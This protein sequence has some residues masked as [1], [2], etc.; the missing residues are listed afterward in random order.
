[1]KGVRIITIDPIGVSIR[2]IAQIDV[3]PIPINPIPDWTRDTSASSV[4]AAPPVVLDIG[5]PIVNIPGC[6]EAHE[7][8]NSKNNKIAEDD[9]K[10]TYT[11]C[12]AGVPSYNPI[13]YEPEQLDYT[14]EAPVPPVKSPEQPEV[15]PPKTEIPPAAT[16]KID[17][18]TPAQQAKEPVGTFIEGFRKKVI[19]YE[20]IGNECVQRT[21]KV[22]LPQQV[23]A[24]LPS[25]GQVVQ[26]GGVAVIATTSALLAKPLADILLKVV[27]PTIKKVMKKIAAI[28]G[29]KIKPLSRTERIN[30]QRDRNHA[31]MALRRV[32]KK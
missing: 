16:A 11:I 18:P 7:T 4:F 23:V 32:V 24:G 28:R 15:V 26:V 27:K 19:G 14:G 29:K 3:S 9:P 20:L 30:E 25:G 17:C 21:E 31:I 13:Q 1:M 12:D 2:P 6:V 5:S 10:G 22:P 8:N